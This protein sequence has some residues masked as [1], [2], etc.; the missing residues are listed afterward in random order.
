ML[1]SPS[2][3]SEPRMSDVIE[4]ASSGRAKCR[5]CR[6]KID[7]GALR[8]GERVPNAFGEGEA[9]LWYHLACAAEKRPEKLAAALREH[10]GEPLE[11]G[12]LERAIA[13]GVENPKLSAVVRAEHAPTGRARCQHCREKIDKD[14]LRV[15]YERDEEPMGM[16]SVSYVHAT[17]AAAHFGRSG[18]VA[19]LERTSP[20]LDD[21][22]R[23]ELRR[24][25]ESAE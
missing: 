6:E 4:P 17:C 18:L 12:E 3:P 9:T 20:G 5:R 13:D 21:A 7:K 15:A 25:I 24:A 11:L 14:V 2:I 1:V 22:D 19:K 23:D 8:F 10:A 16:A